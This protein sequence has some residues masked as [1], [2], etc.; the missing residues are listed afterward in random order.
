MTSRVGVSGGSNILPEANLQRAAHEIRA[1]FPDAR[2]SACYR[3]KAVG[4][5]GP[6]FINFAVVFTAD[7]SVG[8]V[9]RE[10]ER[11]E[12][13]CGRPPGAK[14]WEPRAMDLDILLF[15]DTAGVV[16]GL[17]LPRPSL[18][19]WDFMLRPMAEIAP[20]WVHPTAGRTLADLWSGFDSHGNPL[21]QVALELSA[22]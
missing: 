22:A 8:D 13:L 7:L 18:L 19:E 6:D 21:V 2:F 14:R 9:N 12:A 16:D 1:R 10:L 4:F 15:G 17:T 3:N 5:D 20:D 11:I